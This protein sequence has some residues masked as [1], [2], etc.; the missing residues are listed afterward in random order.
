MPI[1]ILAAHDRMSVSGCRFQNFKT[2]YLPRNILNDTPGIFFF[3]DLDL[4][5]PGGFLSLIIESI[6]P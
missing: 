2:K 3:Y 6:N 5:D 4:V 1:R